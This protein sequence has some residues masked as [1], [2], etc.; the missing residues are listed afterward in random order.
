MQ[1][2]VMR[3]MIIAAGLAASAVVIADPFEESFF[4]YRDGFPSYPGLEPGMVIN[5]GNVDQFREILDEATHR[6]ISSGW[7]EFDVVPT[8]EFTLHEG[9]IEAS[10]A[11]PGKVQLDENGLLVNYVA[12]RAFPAPPDP[13]DPQAGQKLVWSYQYGMNS[14]DSETIYPF[15]WTFR[16]LETAKVERQLR[17]EW[18]FMNWA[19]R[20]QFPPMP[21]FENNP[22]GIY[23]SIYG[24]VLEPFDLSNTQILIQR[25]QNDLKRDDA[26]LYLGF[27]RRVRRLATGQITD[28]FL[29]SDLMIEDFEGYNGRVSDYE[30]QYGGSQLMMAPFYFHNDITDRLEP[31]APA[32][33]DGFR[34]VRFDGQGGC[35]PQVPWQLRKVHK[36]VGTPKDPNHPLSRRDI[37]LDAE[38]AVMPILHVW[39]KKGDFWK[40]FYICKTHS[41]HHMPVNKGKGVP[42]E[43][44][45]V[46]ID[47]QAKHCTTLQFRAMITDEENQPSLFSVQNLRKRAR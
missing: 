4:P 10:R 18:H 31:D 45:A 16:N 32:V 28:A 22:A 34:F 23:R 25:Y 17:F 12:G 37:Y 6:Y 8:A 15:W 33:G 27:Q 14:G 42:V 1:A 44:C 5:Q 3:S 30:W 24:H 20:V 35:F 47:E 29:G 26:W 13:E 19:H 46:L 11:N 21:E 38:T 39:D 41:D 2:T 7:Y 9:Y 43:T 40:T 36:L